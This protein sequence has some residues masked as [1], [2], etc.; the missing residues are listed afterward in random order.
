VGL[1]SDESRQLLCP[2]H[3]SIFDVLDGARPVEGPASHP[4][5]MLP[6]GT[7]ESGFLLARGGFDGPVGAA[8]WGWPDGRGNA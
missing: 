7:D 3:H 1:Y 2:C 8:W 6:L 5:P 4:L